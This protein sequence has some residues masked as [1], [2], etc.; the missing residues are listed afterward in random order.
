MESYTGKSESIPPVP[1]QGTPCPGIEHLHTPYCVPQDTQWAEA[2]AVAEKIVQLTGYGSQLHV[3]DILPDLKDLLTFER[4]RLATAVEG[5]TIK[6]KSEGCYLKGNDGNTY[7]V[8]CEYGN[9][10][11]SGYNKALEAAADL[12]RHSPN[13]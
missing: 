6:R 10:E 2:R 3:N 4:T 8:E 5:M 9:C 11:H 1:P 12:I 7:V 13:K